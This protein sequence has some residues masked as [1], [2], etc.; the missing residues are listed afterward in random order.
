MK[1]Q[2]LGASAR[3]FFMTTESAEYTEAVFGHVRVR[4]WLAREM[5]FHVDNSG[6]RGA[7]VM[8]CSRTY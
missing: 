2:L 4:S 5:Y 6:L 3:V 7:N 8:F 1:T